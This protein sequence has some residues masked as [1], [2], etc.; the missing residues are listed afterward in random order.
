MNSQGMTK[1]LTLMAT[2]VFN[3][4][5]AIFGRMFWLWVLVITGLLVWQNVSDVP[6]YSTQYGVPEQNVYIDPKPTACDWGHAPLGSK[7]CHFEKVFT[8][9]KNDAGRVTE[10]HISWARVK[11]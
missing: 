9:V 3:F 6:R 7:D 2:A 1:A 8:L 4:L 10:V 11:D 5:W